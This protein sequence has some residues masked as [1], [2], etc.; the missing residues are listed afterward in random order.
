MSKQMS[1]KNSATNKSNRVENVKK[2]KKRN[3]IICAIAIVFVL[4]IIIDHFNQKNIYNNNIAKNIFIE[5]VDVSKMTKEKAIE[6]VV[7]NHSPKSIYLSYEGKKYEILPT[8]IDLKY[9]VEET[10]EEAY[11][12]TKTDKY[13]ENIKRYF[14]LKGDKK[15]IQLKSSY[16][17]A[18]LSEYIQKMSNEINVDMENAKIYVSSSG[19]ISTNPSI[20]GK[21][22]D[23][24]ST[25]ESIINNIKNKEY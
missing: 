4:G 21:E 9:N 20:T 12:Y 13:F 1:N 10:V 3:S 15:D 14:H 23:I 8:D 22:L 19:R 18:K 5:N 16:D 6:A 24:A 17:E 2:N 7:S 25:K 11:N